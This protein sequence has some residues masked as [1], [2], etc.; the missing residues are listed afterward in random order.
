M[1][2]NLTSLVYPL[3]VNL[4]ITMEFFCKGQAKYVSI[5]AANA[6]KRFNTM[7]LNMFSQNLVCI[8]MLV[9][10]LV[11]AALCQSKFNIAGSCEKIFDQ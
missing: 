9:Y 6:F 5:T 3:L 2:H 8:I 10:N 11:H 7:E 1:A 4:D